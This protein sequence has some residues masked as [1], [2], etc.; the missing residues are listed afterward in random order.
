MFGPSNLMYDQRASLL[1]SVSVKS[2]RACDQGGQM[3][4]LCSD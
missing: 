2:S 4:M 3:E 1:C